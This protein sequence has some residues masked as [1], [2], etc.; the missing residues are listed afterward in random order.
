LDLE[1]IE[2]LAK[3][4]ISYDLNEAEWRCGGDEVHL[5]RRSPQMSVSPSLANCAFP[6][7][8]EVRVSPSI[9]SGKS[10][11]CDDGKSSLHSINSPMVGTFYRAPAPDRPAFVE[12]GSSIKKNTTVC[13]LEAMKVLSEIPAEV[14]GVIVDVLVKDGQAVEFGQPLFRVRLDS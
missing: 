2:G 8:Q 4:L 7:S 3:L 6:G 12:I 13:I 9:A 10:T 14:E 1:D 11:E 5:V